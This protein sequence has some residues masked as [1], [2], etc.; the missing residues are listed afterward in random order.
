[1]MFVPILAGSWKLNVHH[2]PDCPF[3][4]RWQARRYMRESA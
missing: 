1:M 2:D 4:Q 3:L